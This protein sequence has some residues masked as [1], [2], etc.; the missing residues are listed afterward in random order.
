MALPDLRFLCPTL[1]Y[2]Y[3]LGWNQSPGVK[4]S[5]LRRAEL[6]TDSGRGQGTPSLDLKEERESLIRSTGLAK[7]FFLL[8][9]FMGTWAQS[10]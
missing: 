5:G 3:D 4:A 9:L 6:S 7:R 8:L 1:P 10:K 2:F